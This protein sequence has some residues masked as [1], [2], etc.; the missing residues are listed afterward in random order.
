MVRASDAP[1]VLQNRL[2]DASCDA[3]VK[4]GR[5]EHQ[6]DVMKD[7]CE[8]ACDEYDPALAQAKK[9]MEEMQKKQK[10][11][12]GETTKEKVYED[13]MDE[14][15]CASMAREGKCDTQPDITLEF[16]E[17]TCYELKK[18]LEYFQTITI[19][20]DTDDSFYE[21]SARDSNGSMINFDGFDGYIT[22]VVNIGMTCNS[23]E[24]KKFASNIEKF[25]KLMPYTLK[26]IVFP[27]QM[28]SSSSVDS[29]QCLSS[30]KSILKEVP[31][32][33]NV[34]IMEI[35]DINGPDIHPVYKYLKDS[36]K[37]ETMKSDVTTFFF[38]NPMGTKI[39]VL[40]GQTYGK[41]KEHVNRYLKYWEEL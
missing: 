19:D 18:S 39:D 2:D 20:E 9:M 38:V 10:L 25:R 8:K 17:K 15:I 32:R 26:L 34:H 22:A 24:D 23:M 7:F 11:G 33:K 41:V 3:M 36:A 40:I 5:C 16:C 4:E 31:P 27:F 35:V 30:V 37:I 13:R 14:K 29:S 12:G 28:S 1:R 21:L 6:P